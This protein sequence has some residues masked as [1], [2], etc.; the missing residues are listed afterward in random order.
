VKV[1][2]IVPA[3]GRGIRFNR[4]KRKIFANLNKRPLLLHTLRNLQ[5][6]PLVKDIVLVID[7]SLL[8]GG[9]RLVKFNRVTKVRHIVEG[10]RS[11]FESVRRGLR[12]VDKDTSLVLIHDGVRPFVSKEMVKKTVSAAKKFGAS[13]A[14]VPVK[15]TI[16]VSRDGS[17]VRYTPDRSKLWEIQTPQVFRKSLLEAAYK[18]VKSN[19]LFTLLHERSSRN[20]RPRHLMKF[21]DDAVLIE[22]IGKKVKIVRGDYKNIKITTTED[23]RIAEALLRRG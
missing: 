18:K 22:N 21:T 9:E 5:S 4:K 7:K 11:R 10:G 23:M 2:A 13:I 17:F 12:Y 3:A 8:K 16:K 20:K 15:S 6:S 14:A 1:T 19:N